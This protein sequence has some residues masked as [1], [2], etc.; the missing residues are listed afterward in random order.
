MAPVSWA[1]RPLHAW[2]MRVYGGAVGSGLL[3]VP[4]YPEA[5][6]SGALGPLPDLAVGGPGRYR[7]RVH[8][9]TRERDEDDP[10]APVE[11]HL[12]VAFPLRS[13]GK[14]AR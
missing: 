1:C 7:L 10:G 13:P 2:T 6:D 12:L 8:A 14:L 3:V 11:D 5:G 4:P 9:R